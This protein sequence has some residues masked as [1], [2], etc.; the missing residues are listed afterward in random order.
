MQATSVLPKEAGWASTWG[1]DSKQEGQKIF[2]R[3][4]ASQQKEGVDGRAKEEEMLSVMGETAGR[5]VSARGQAMR[6]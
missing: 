1:Q 4:R 6:R 3:D 2:A 5:R